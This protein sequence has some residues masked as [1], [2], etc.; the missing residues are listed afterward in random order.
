MRWMEK[1]IPTTYDGYDVV[2]HHAKVGSDRTTRAGC[3]CEHVVIGNDKQSIAW[4][5][6]Q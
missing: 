4:Y 1:T 6:F 5:H 2:Y 3:R